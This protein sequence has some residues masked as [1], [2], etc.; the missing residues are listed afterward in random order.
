MARDGACRKGWARDGTSVRAAHGRGSSP[1]GAGR[2]LRTRC[3]SR[4][5]W[6]LPA[7]G[8][9]VLAVGRSAITLPVAVLALLACGGSSEPPAADTA[10]VEEMRL[11]SGITVRDYAANVFDPEP[12]TWVTKQRK[13]CAA[14][15]VIISVE[16]CL[17][18]AAIQVCGSWFGGIDPEDSKYTDCVADMQYL[19]GRRWADRCSRSAGEATTAQRK[20]GTSTPGSMTFVRS[21]RRWS[22]S[23]RSCWDSPSAASLP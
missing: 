5:G 3:P 1:A 17:N 4:G 6:R 9:R 22:S 15:T 12:M 23:T 7:F 18:E 13:T 8:R 19:A 2:W 16:K 20:S 14:S 21:A 10:T 11:P